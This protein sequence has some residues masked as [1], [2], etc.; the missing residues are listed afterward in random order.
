LDDGLRGP[1]FAPGIFFPSSRMPLS[2]YDF[3]FPVERNKD[4][5]FAGKRGLSTFKALPQ[6]VGLED[7]RG[8]Y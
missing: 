2:S 1:S 3:E 5:Q 7:G 6:V 4:R 8:T